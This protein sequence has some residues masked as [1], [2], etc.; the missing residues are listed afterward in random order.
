MSLADSG[1]VLLELVGENSDNYTI[2]TEDIR[3]LFS[4]FGEVQDVWFRSQISAV[5]T[6]EEAVSA[7]FAAKYLHGFAVDS[8]GVTLSVGLYRDPPQT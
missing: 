5:V 4:R 7:L 3:E 6:F 8:A 1:Q 2:Q